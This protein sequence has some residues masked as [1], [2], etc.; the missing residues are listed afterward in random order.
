M[1]KVVIERPRWNP[2]PNKFG[3]AANLPDELL[4]KYQGMR[5][6][7]ACRKAF[8]DLLGPLRRW[9]QSQVGRPWNDVYSEACQVIKSDS[10]VRLHIKTHL[11]QFVERHTLMHE[12]EVCVLDLYKRR[13]EP[14]HSKRFG[15]VQFYV[16]P[17]S[18]LLLDV[19]P[20]SRRNWR[21]EQRA[22]KP[23]TLTWLTNDSALKQIKGIWF[24][25]EFREIPPHKPF[26]AYDHTLCQVVG[27]G[28][29]TYR[30]RKSLHCISKRQLSRREL[31]RYGLTNA[32]ANFEERPLQ[33]TF[34]H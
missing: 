3:R 26:K 24:M 20:E 33:C 1:H 23:P 34:A 29:L 32:A 21:K 7:Y 25:C 4:P 9:L 16:H 8:T 19:K 5:Q 30:D 14:I 27:R 6:P 2:G 10:V 18:G 15:W 22:K 28:S 17:E 31:R 12:G 11:F 13:P